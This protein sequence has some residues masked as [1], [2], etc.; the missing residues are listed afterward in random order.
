LIGFFSIAH[1]LFVDILCTSLTLSTR[2]VFTKDSRIEPDRPSLLPAFDDERLAQFEAF[3]AGLRPVFHRAD[4][5]LRFR[6]YLRGLLEPAERKNVESIAAAAARSMMV[7]SDL[8]QALQHFV[9]QSPWD[10]RRLLAAVRRQSAVRRRDSQAVW[11][12]HDGAFPKKGQHSVGVHRQFARSVGR[13]LNCQVGVFVS[14]IGPSGFYP[15]TAR[16]YLPG[17]W[18]KESSEQAEKTI[19]E[20]SRKPTGKAEIALS[21]IAELLDDG[22]E[23]RPIVAEAG[24]SASEEFAN[25]LA[26]R[27]L[28]VV[29]DAEERLAVVLRR[30]EWLKAE[31]GLDHFEGRTW[32]GWHHHVSLVFTAYHFLAADDP[33]TDSPPFTSLSR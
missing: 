8:A 7:E 19:P 5:A 10:S 17:A 21:Q 11:A 28:T 4:Q 12:V 14:Q 9:S 2:L 33:T 6:A 31:L 22:E 30:I 29:D 27:G 25:G 20:D 3:V 18:L 23:P 24:Y 32:L 15:L 26:S 13:K 1:G 16:L